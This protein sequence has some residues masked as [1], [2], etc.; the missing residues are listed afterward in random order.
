MV[1]GYYTKFN[2]QF[3]E[4]TINSFMLL[5]NIKSKKQDN[6]KSSIKDHFVSRNTCLNWLLDVSREIIRI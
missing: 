4:I 6:T 2:Q 5:S 1:K 3:F